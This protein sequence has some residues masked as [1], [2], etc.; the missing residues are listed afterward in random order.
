MSNYVIKFA[1][2]QDI[3]SLI[4]AGGEFCKEYGLPFDKESLIHTA[5]TVLQ[6]GFGVVITDGETLC[7]VVGALIQPSIFKNDYLQCNEVMYYV[8]PEYRGDGVGLQ[9]LESYEKV[10]KDKGCKYATLVAPEA[11][12][13]AKL[14]ILYRRKK[15][16]EFETTYLK[17]L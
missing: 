11:L 14:D 13:K 17:E 7:G 3:P 9:L 4:A 2:E 8:Y 6:H 15:F 16:K 10:A 5:H 1:T 12:K